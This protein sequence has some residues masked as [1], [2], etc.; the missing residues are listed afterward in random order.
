MGFPWRIVLFLRFLWYPAARLDG[1]KAAVD[2]F[3]R[4]PDIEGA[5][6]AAFYGIRP[7]DKRAGTTV[8]LVTKDHASQ[9][10]FRSGGDRA[11]RPR[12]R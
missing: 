9:Q 7:G 11:N 10:G 8:L 12:G 2:A 6:V 4:L 3:N 5:L 1:E